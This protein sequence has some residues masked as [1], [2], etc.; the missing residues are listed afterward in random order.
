[1][2]NLDALLDTGQVISGT[3]KCIL[4]RTIDELAEPYSSALRNLL[5]GDIASAV[6]SHRIK[7]AGLKGSDRTIQLHRRG[8]C[9]CPVESASE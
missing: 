4:G 7:A 2:A 5:D 9:G 1:M 6:V 8:I 3:R